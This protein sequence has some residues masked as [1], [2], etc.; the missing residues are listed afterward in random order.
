MAETLAT[1]RDR[2]EQILEDSSNDKWATGEL[3]E[4]IEQALDAYSE[5]LPR[6]AIGTVTLASAGREV[7]IS[8]I[9]YREIRRV[10]WDY[11]SSDPNY[12][13]NWREFELWPGDILF[14][15]DDDEPAATDV[16]RVFYTADHTLEDLNS[17][18]STTFPDRHA[19]LLARGA[20]ALAV[21]FRRATVGETANLN[22]WAPR[23]LRDWAEEQLK[24]FYAE[25]DELAQREAALSSGTIPLARIDRWDTDENDW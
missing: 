25:L 16:V 6:E 11:D 1:L 12:P 4:A 17:A 8:S 5:R 18:A 13:P 3:D 10:W 2:V 24:A 19:S 7:D 20:A 9:T 15:R 22:E 14:I 21:L 23:N